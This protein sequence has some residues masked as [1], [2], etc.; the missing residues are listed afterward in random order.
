[1]IPSS[2]LALV[3]APAT[4]RSQT[5]LQLPGS[6]LLPKPQALLLPSLHPPSHQQLCAPS[7]AEIPPSPWPRGAPHFISTPPDLPTAT[8]PPAEQH[9]ENIWTAFSP[10][11]SPLS[12]S[13][14]TTRP[15]WGSVSPLLLPPWAQH[16][17]GRL[18]AP[19]SASPALFLNTWQCWSLYRSNRVKITCK[20]I[21]FFKMKIEGK[22]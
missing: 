20:N 3:R 19:I 1:M 4:P 12:I 16:P 13:H 10:G 5:C 22:I 7:P 2:R 21:Y 8:E 9:P 14:L 17:S 6:D 11:G 15:C 18:S